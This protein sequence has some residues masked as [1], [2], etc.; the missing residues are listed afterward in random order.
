MPTHPR[1]STAQ[2][3]GSSYKRAACAI[4]RKNIPQ[5]CSVVGMHGAI[6]MKPIQKKSPISLC[7]TVLKAEQKPLLNTNVLFVFATVKL[8]ACV[9]S[10][11]KVLKRKDMN[12]PVVCRMFV[13][14]I[15]M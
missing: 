8:F 7:L 6:T 1:Y 11:K 4:V 14:L 12:L 13:I 3:A 10:E 15:G 9:E 5:V 2:L